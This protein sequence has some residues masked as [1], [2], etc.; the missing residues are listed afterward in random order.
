MAEINEETR[1][2]RYGGYMHDV[3]DRVLNPEKYFVEESRIEERN[4]R[5]VIKVTPLAPVAGVNDRDDRE[6]RNDR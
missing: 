5:K 4:G 2:Y 6:D 1:K 3:I